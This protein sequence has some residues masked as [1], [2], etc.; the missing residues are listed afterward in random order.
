MT[1]SI[2]LWVGMLVPILYFGTQILAAP[3]YRGYSFLVHSAS[4]LGSPRS[5]RPWILN[6]GAVTTGVAILIAASA[7]PSA[8]RRYDCPRPLAWCITVAMVSMGFGAL[9]A[10]TFPLP[11]PRHN[12]RL[13]GAGAFL[14][15]VLL[16]FA[17][18]RRAHATALNAYLFVNLVLFLLLIPVMS[19]A[20]FDISSYRGILQRIAAAVLYVP[21]SVVAASLHTRRRGTQ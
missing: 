6:T 10:G 1:R 16:P 12:P 5:D 19:G 9:W 8:L 17:T 18:R 4:E 11:D 3:F 21:V 2:A 15:P 14:L 7:F 13:I 20:V